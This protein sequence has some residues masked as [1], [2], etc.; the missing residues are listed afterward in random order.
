M[1]N[2][3]EAGNESIVWVTDQEL[4]FELYPPLRDCP[5]CHAEAVFLAVGVYWDDYD[6][7]RWQAAVRCCKPTCVEGPVRDSSFG[8]KQAIYRACNAWN[9]VE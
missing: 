4:R 6:G 1:I 7:G 8:A 9:G 5:F 3:P 2:L